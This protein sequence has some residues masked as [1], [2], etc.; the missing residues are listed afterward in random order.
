MADLQKI[1]SA[2]FQ[3]T[4]VA[5]R[6]RVWNVLCRHFFND[7][8]GTEKTVLDLACGYGEFIN[9][10]SA[11]TK[12]A[13]DLNPDSP[14]FLDPDVK[15]HAVPATDLGVISESSIDVVFTSNFL[16]HLQD[17][18]ECDKV[19]AE[20]RRILK[21]GGRFIIMGPNIRYAQKEYWDYYDHNLPLSHLSLGEGLTQAGF[22]VSTIIP[23][24]LP[25]TMN[26]SMPTSDLLVRAYLKMPVAWRFFGKQ[27]LVVA[28]KLP[29]AQ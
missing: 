12:V 2:R 6:R 17:K 27:F 13:V 3:Q 28:E 19:F 11:A 29:A 14:R 8:I 21:V 18:K 20:V 25:Y 10:V 9:E 26:S 4:G 23:R 15:Y 7:L 5:K 24:F 16:E 1:Y 22:D